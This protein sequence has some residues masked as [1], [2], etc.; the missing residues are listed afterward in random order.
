[1]EENINADD[2]SVTTDYEAMFRDSEFEKQDGS[3][4]ETV[5]Q[6]SDDTTGDDTIVTDTVSETDGTKQESETS[7]ASKPPTRAPN[8]SE[9]QHNLRVQMFNDKLALES[10]STEEETSLIKAHIKELRGALAEESGKSKDSTNVEQKISEKPVFEQDEA[11][12]VNQYLKENGFMTKVEVEEII[13][14]TTKNVLAQAKQQFSNEATISEQQ[15][16]IDSFFK[17]REDI[18]G[19]ARATLEKFVLDNYKVTPQTSGQQMSVILD[20]SANYLFPKQQVQRDQH[21]KATI[22]DVSG[23]QSGNIS[24][25]S[26]GLDSDLEKR[27]AENGTVFKGWKF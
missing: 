25:S 8:E 19:P 22:A 23:N 1:M 3:G 5:T 6:S 10:A 9:I 4:A 14:E 17:G 24:T 7:K 18:N 15:S 11:E 16:A 20:M 27:L 13:K 2:G 12:A 26:K 21:T